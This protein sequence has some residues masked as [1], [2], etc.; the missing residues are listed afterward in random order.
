MTTWGAGTTG[1]PEI[2]LAKDATLHHRRLEESLKKQHTHLQ[3][4]ASHLF[5][6]RGLL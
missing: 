1:C 6:S 5:V 3:R 4:A 2:H